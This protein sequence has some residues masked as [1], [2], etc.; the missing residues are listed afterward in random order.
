[1]RESR[2]S[3]A[4]WRPCVLR[5]ARPPGRCSTPLA[6]RPPFRALR[7][8]A[9][10]GVGLRGAALAGIAA[11]RVAPDTGFACSAFAAPAL[12][13]AGAALTAVDHR[14]LA[15]PPRVLAAV[16]T[17]RLAA[18]PFAPQPRVHACG[19]DRSQGLRRTVPAPPLGRRLFAR[20]GTSLCPVLAR[21]LV[22]RHACILVGLAHTQGPLD[23]RGFGCG[24]LSADR[25]QEIPR[26]FKPALS[27]MDGATAARADDHPQRSGQAPRRNRPPR[28]RRGPSGCE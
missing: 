27:P 13:A 16:A 20:R 9:P 15:S 5:R 2:R 12:V 23:A 7:P 18:S 6:L 19:I 11:P 17:P 24:R 4:L 26:L 25:V 22:R 1:M 10:G 21:H 28:A 3:L 14:L 8:R